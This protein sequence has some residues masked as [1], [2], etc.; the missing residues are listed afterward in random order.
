MTRVMTKICDSIDTTEMYNCDGFYVLPVESAYTIRYRENEKFFRT[1][2]RA[3]VMERINGSI[4]AHVWNKLTAE[5]KLT[6]ESDVA[7]IHLAREFC[8]K[9]L[10]ASTIF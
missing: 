7:Y 5:R 10:K 6:V 2:Y 3:E 4:I 9:V 8:P 1:E